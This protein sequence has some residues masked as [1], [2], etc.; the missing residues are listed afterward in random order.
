MHLNKFNFK[1][2]SNYIL[3]LFFF[4]FIFFG[5]LTK[6]LKIPLGA[7]VISISEILLFILI[8]F[9]IF[10]NFKIFF[11]F[12]KC[13]FILIFMI[14]VS[15][16]YGSL[17]N[18]FEINSLIYALRLIFLLMSGFFIGKIF[19]VL[20]I[21][22]KNQIF[23]FYI[24]TYVF[25]SIFSLIILFLF[26]DSTKL[27][28]FMDSFGG[29]FRG[30]P[31]QNRLVSV[32]LDPNYYGAIICLPISILLGKLILKQNLRD[33]FFFLIMVASL[34][35]SGSRSGLGALLIILFYHIIVII[36]I[37]LERRTVNLKLSLSILFIVSTG[38]ILY[39]NFSPYFQRTVSRISNIESDE[40][41]FVRFDSFEI[42]NRYILENPIFGI[43]YNYFLKIAKKDRGLNAL[44]SSL[45][46]VLVNFGIPTFILFFFLFSRWFFKVSY[47]N[48]ILDLPEKQ[49]FSSFNIYLLV[50]FLFTSAFNNV[51]FYSF[52]LVPVI[53]FLTFMNSHLRDKYLRSNPKYNSI[54]DVS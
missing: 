34:I 32:Y 13:N 21:R 41:A 25:I 42:G 31:H 3:L 29:N 16:I 4:I 1:F 14:L 26:P 27:W 24:S 11:D 19:Y 40:S 20:S 35:L 18:Q 46:N 17:V 36:K 51:L 43:G 33:L 12:L 44:D 37:S 15:F 49:I 47:Y 53:S 8:G 30:D 7:D 6:I 28:D 54:G 23:D 5:N 52:W 10:F 9:K 39:P 38:I 45:Q 22:G 50:T 2:K 48:R